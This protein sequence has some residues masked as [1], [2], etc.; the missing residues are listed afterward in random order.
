[1][2]VL[3]DIGFGMEEFDDL[4]IR[5]QSVSDIIYFNLVDWKTLQKTLGESF[6]SIDKYYCE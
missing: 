1:M 5:H 2:L 4:E 6:Y 3:V